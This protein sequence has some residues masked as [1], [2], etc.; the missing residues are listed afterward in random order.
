VG[1]VSFEIEDRIA[2]VKFTNP[3]KGFMDVG[4]A[5]RLNEILDELEEDPTVRVIVFTGGQPEQFIRHFSVENLLDYGA[6][7][8]NG[9]E[10][11]L[12]D[13]KF[14]RKQV[15]ASWEKIDS[16]QKPTIAAINGFC[17][18]GGCELALCCDI[19]LAGPGNY[20]IGQPEIQ[21]GILPG[22]AATARLA[23]AVGTGKALEWVL[24]G[25]LFSP[26]EAAREGLVHHFIPSDVLVANREIAKEFLDKPPRALASI[27][28][29]IRASADQPLVESLDRES[30]AFVYLS[31]HDAYA[32]KM[33][34]DYVAG[35]HKLRKV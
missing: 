34:K 2:V 17:M 10:A 29:P 35:G 28:Q 16:S 18:G 14:S 19:R 27:K 9:A 30:S 12:P 26:E 13:P 32:V 6:S 5:L 11:G 22:A 15:R 7:V 1:T 20:T 3:N 4:M 31:S 33:M 25:R 21:V 23:R 8:R 24:R